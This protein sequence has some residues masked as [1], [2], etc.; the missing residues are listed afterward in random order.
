MKTYKL[1]SSGGTSSGNDYADDA[2]RVNESV[3][4]V[5]VWHGKYIDGIQVVYQTPQGSRHELPAHGGQG[6]RLEIFTLDADE[7]I[8]GIC[9]KYAKYLG[10]LQIITNKQPSTFFGEGGGG[11]EYCYQVPDG[12]EIIGFWGRNGQ[13]LDSVG[14]LARSLSRPA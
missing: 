10:S 3:V 14:I 13:Y 12:S 8:T 2:I 7:Y 5:R 9:R 11:A 6:G 1:G 4:E